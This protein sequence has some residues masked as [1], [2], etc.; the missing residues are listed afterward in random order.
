MKLISSCNICIALC[1][2]IAAVSSASARVLNPILC[3]AAPRP[4]AT[5]NVNAEFACPSSVDVI[6]IT[7]GEA[8]NDYS[9]SEGLIDPEIDSEVYPSN[10]TDVRRLHDGQQKEGKR[11][12]CFCDP[13]CRSPTQSSWCMQFWCGYCDRR[14]LKQLQERVER[15]TEEE[16]ELITVGL[17]STAQSRLRLLATTETNADCRYF[18]KNAT[19]KVKLL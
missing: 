8:L 4:G 6:Q 7:V 11:E 12:L 18:L 2:L 14:G 9:I 17:A 13:R 1:I 3:D 5:T 10:E 16:R 19:C 15:M